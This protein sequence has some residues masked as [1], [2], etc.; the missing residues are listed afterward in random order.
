MYNDTFSG[1]LFYSLE[2]Y[3]P[4]TNS[5]ACL[6]K[7]LCIIHNKVNKKIGKPIFDCNMADERWRDKGLVQTGNAAW[8]LLHTMT[9]RYPENPTC[10]QKDDTNQFFT[11][12]SRL[13]PCPSCASDFSRL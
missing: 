4:D 12:F 2:A 13:Y 6:T 7:W 3:P 9:A 8:S 11:L 5:R 1:N 10:Q